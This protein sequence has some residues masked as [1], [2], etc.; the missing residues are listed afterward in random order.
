MK[1]LASKMT[2]IL[3]LALS[4]SAY[5]QIGMN[6]TA[7]RGALDINSPTTND[8]GL[9]L[10]TNADPK[11]LINPMGGSIAEGTVMYDSTLRCIRFFRPTGWSNCLSDNPTPAFQLDCNGTL[12]GTYTAGVSSNGTKIINYTGGQ[13][14]AYAAINIASTGVTG[15]SATAP[16][17]TMANGSGSITLTISGT[18]SA[19]GTANFTVNLGGTSCSFQVQVG[20]NN[21]FTFK[22]DQAQF[23]GITSIGGISTGQ[24][25][26]PYTNGNG[27][28]Y[29][30]GQTFAS[31]Q[32]TGLTATS[33]P[34]VLD[35]N[36][37]L[38]FTISGS[39]SSQ[40]FAVFNIMV[41][42]STCTVKIIVPN[43]NN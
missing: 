8:K 14:Q 36:N 2:D 18:P 31:S 27:A 41:L 32:V 42:N 1:N 10:P 16:A 25:R 20:S 24:L 28:S 4:L 22:C 30:G 23:F 11:N 39:A 5:S 26:I 35:N 17:G 43:Q 34:T 21:N 37:P 40:G 13:G 15:L 19:T 6:T 12:T 33:L 3:F 29:A 9:V 7:P 38:D